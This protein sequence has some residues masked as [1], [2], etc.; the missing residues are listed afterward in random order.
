[1]QAKRGGDDRDRV[2]SD[3]DL[4]SRLACYMSGACHAGEHR[5]VHDGPL[6][7]GGFSRRLE[8]ATGCGVPG[9]TI[10]VSDTSGT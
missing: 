2:Q 9:A 5:R 4:G 10:E 6:H 1:M 8:R 7:R 3:A